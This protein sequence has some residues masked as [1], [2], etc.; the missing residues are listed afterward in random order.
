MKT[1]TMGIVKRGVGIRT[2]VGKKEAGS[3][4]MEREFVLGS[5]AQTNF[6]RIGGSA[7]CGDLPGLA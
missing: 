2:E 3:F 6:K 7:T 5:P 4:W 1:T